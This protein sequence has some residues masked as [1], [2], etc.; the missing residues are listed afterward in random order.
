M[1]VPHSNAE[2]APGFVGEHDADDFAQ[3]D[4]DNNLSSDLSA[5]YWPTFK[6]IMEQVVDILVHLESFRNVDLYH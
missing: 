5:N 2:A 1:P 6:T 3:F 4:S